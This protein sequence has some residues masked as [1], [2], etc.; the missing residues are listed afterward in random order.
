MSSSWCCQSDGIIC[1]AFGLYICKTNHN[2]KYKCIFHTGKVWWKNGD[3]L[4]WAVEHKVV[5][6]SGKYILQDALFR[7]L[8]FVDT[9]EVI[10][11]T[12][13]KDSGTLYKYLTE[14]AMPKALFLCSAKNIGYSFKTSAWI[15]KLSI[16]SALNKPKYAAYCLAFPQ[17]WNCTQN[18][19]LLW[20]ADCKHKYSSTVFAELER[21]CLDPS[22][23]FALK[24]LCTR[25]AGLLSDSTLVALLKFINAEHQQIL[26]ISG[27]THIELQPGLDKKQIQYTEHTERT[28]IS[29][30]LAKG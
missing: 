29:S 25:T 15:I 2:L 3:V 14:C 5:S 13:A 22:T 19:I 20:R 24:F 6:S 4:F 16:S 8:D 11:F 26:P 7:I 28:D 9:E 17:W 27:F 12:E 1:F 23:C 21:M 30:I 18:V 10:Q